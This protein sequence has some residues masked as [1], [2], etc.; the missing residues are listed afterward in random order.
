MSQPFKLYRLQQIDSQLDHARLRLQEIENILNNDSTLRQAQAEASTAE[1]GLQA[2]AKALR[3]AEADVQA[4]RIKIEQTESTLYGGKVRNPKE[5]QDLQNES[6]AL[7]RYVSVLEDR[8]LECMLAVEEAEAIQKSASDR[9]EEVIQNLNLQHASLHSERANLQ[10]DVDRLE[11]ERQATSAN[12]AAEDLD[13]YEKLRQQR[14]GVAVA[15]ISDNAC[16]ACGSTLTPGLIQT[17]RNSGQLS[18]CTFCGRILYS[19]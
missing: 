2:A 19:G 12:I 8:Q 13:L 18:R 16:A 6:A 9:L 4:Q 11:T 17:V 5:L 14:R 15:K 10:K 3:Q 7:K 1:N